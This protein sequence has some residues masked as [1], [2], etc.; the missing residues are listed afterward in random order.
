MP[1]RAKFRDVVGDDNNITT[2]DRTYIGN[3]EP[4]FTGGFVN[5]FNYKGFDLNIF[6]SFSYGGKLFVTNYY[7]AIRL[8]LYMVSTPH[9]KY[10]AIYYDYYNH[11]PDNNWS[12]TIYHHVRMTRKYSDQI[13][14]N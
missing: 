6:L 7:P 5:K 10:F 3:S 9:H 4:K 8:N 11:K 12:Q 1:G 13:L 14:Y 2:D